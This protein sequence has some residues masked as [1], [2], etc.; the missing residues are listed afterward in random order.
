MIDAVASY[1]RLSLFITWSFSFGRP[2]YTLN[3]LTCFDLF[4]FDV[5]FSIE[6]AFHSKAALDSQEESTKSQNWNQFKCLF[7]TGDDFYD[8]AG[9]V[10]KH[11]SFAIIESSFLMNW[12]IQTHKKAKLELAKNVLIMFSSC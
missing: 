12:N 6:N 7:E 5:S 2:F 1:F 8:R 11:I 10:L 3:C 9:S 4:G